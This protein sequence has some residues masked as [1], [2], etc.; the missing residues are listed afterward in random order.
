MNDVK[1]PVEIAACTIV[2]ESLF[3]NIVAGFVKD[4]FID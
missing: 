3:H 2:D 1:K 4:N